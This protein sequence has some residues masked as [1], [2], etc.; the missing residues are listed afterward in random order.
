[1][2]RCYQ[3]MDVDL[4]Y[5]IY[6]KYYSEEFDFPNFFRKFICAVVVEDENGPVIVG[7]VKPIVEAIILTDKD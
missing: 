6:R 3:P 5:E 4:A 1:M 2:V 7:G